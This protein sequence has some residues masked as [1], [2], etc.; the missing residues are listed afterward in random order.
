MPR[1]LPTPSRLLLVGLFPLLYVRPLSSSSPSPSLISDSFDVPP[2]QPQS[3]WVQL[4]CSHSS[5]CCH[6]PT[7]SSATSRPT[8]HPFGAF[9]SINRTRR[10]YG[11]HC[12]NSFGEVMT[13]AHRAE[14][15]K[16]CH[17]L[18]SDIRPRHATD[19]PPNLSNVQISLHI[20]IQLVC[21]R[22]HTPYS[23]Q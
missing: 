1:S 13:S 6:S 7:P 12:P 14:N 9:R 23:R 16:R 2:S 21:E 17:Q 11:P 10:C 20:W 19:W 15:L 4:G 22:Y 18:Q 8:S 3:A 5:W